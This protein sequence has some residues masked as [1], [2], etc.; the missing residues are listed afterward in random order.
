MEV[1][2]QEHPTTK[3]TTIRRDHP[4]LELVE[5][6]LLLDAVVFSGSAALFT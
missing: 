4:V 5:E 2:H 1:Q 6:D 3:S